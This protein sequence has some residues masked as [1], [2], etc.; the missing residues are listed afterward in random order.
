MTQFA[1]ISDIHSN[2]VALTEVLKDIKL[3]GIDKIVCA[4][5]IVGYNPFPR[6]TLSKILEICDPIIKGN[7]DHAVS[8]NSPLK[9]DFG[10]TE[11]ARIASNWTTKQLNQMERKRLYSLPTMLEMPIDGKRITMVH[12][13][14]EYPLDEYVYDNSEAQKNC[15]A[16]IEMFNL[17]ILIMGHTHI[18]YVRKID[19]RLLVNCGSVGQPRDGNPRASYA[20]I[21]PETMSATIRRV[22]YDIEEVFKGIIKVGLPKGLADRLF[23]G[24]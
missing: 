13:G 1:A 15:I 7:H 20:I 11:I 2:I 10:F 24:K 5:D 6:E 16:F 22:K 23:V 9:D 8:L 12:G 3:K 21:D 18:P 14:L 19:N 17:D 4:G